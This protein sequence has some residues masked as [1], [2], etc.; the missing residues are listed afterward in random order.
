M[1]YTELTRKA[2]KISFEAHKDQ[3]DRSGM[4]Y[5][6]HPYEVAS[7]MDDEYSTCVA[8]LHDVIEDTDITSDSLRN[9]GFPEEVVQALLC[10]TRDKSVP[11]M[12][13]IRKI[14]TNTIAIKVKVAD[15]THNE[16]TIL[17]KQSPT[18]IVKTSPCSSNALPS[19]NS[20]SISS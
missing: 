7:H 14:M 19:G 17:I 20:T 1:I 10:M 15:L 2:L 12:D 5:V 13:Y 8:L 18:G 16:T 6:Y 11:Y 9:E 3:T 4:P